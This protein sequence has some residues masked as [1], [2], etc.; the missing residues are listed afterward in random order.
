MKFPINQLET[1]VLYISAFPAP[2]NL[3]SSA[4]CDS[5]RDIAP[6]S[7]KIRRIPNSFHASYPKSIHIYTET[8]LWRHAHRIENVRERERGRERD[9][10]PA[11]TKFCVI[12]TPAAYSDFGRKRE[13][14]QPE[15]FAAIV[16]QKQR[17][18]RALHNTHTCVY[19]ITTDT[20][21]HAH[22][23]QNF[24]RQWNMLAG[25]I[26]GRNLVLAGVYTRLCG[27]KL[28]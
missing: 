28:R 20:L 21:S 11:A 10:K 25:E 8:L 6:N 22:P 15:T 7:R 9:E 17:P 12:R 16:L 18:R 19:S 13:R 23:L 26:C 27:S 1:I 24:D 2:I 5:G 3:H 14:Q 4:I